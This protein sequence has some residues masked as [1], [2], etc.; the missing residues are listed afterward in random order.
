MTKPT[1]TIQHLIDQ[2]KQAEKEEM[3]LVDE[4]IRLDDK[5]KDME[6]LVEQ[7]DNVLKQRMNATTKKNRFKEML[8]ELGIPE[9]EL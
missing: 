3:S 7:R 8:A 5:L 9:H 6:R 1:K 4:K 2:F